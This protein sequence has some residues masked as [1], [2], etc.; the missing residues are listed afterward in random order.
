M[1]NSLEHL[2]YESVDIFDIAKDLDRLSSTL[3]QR[4]RL[5]RKIQF[6]LDIRGYFVINKIKGNYVEFGVYRGEMMYGAFSVL[7]KTGALKNY[8]GLDTF[9]GEPEPTDRER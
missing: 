1:T 2:T 4:H 3:D 9:E 5:Q 7:G 6:F 8:I